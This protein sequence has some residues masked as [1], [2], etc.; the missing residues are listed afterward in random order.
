M[1]A[2]VARAKSGG[3]G[4]GESNKVDGSDEGRLDIFRCRAILPMA[5]SSRESTS[6]E[7]H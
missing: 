4:G 6:R 5:R 7:C 1:S 3:G 2:L